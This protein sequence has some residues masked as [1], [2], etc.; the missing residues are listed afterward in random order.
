MT[1]GDRHGLWRRA[2]AS[3]VSS[4]S[5][6]AWPREIELCRASLPI[7]LAHPGLPKPLPCLSSWAFL[8][9]LAASST[10]L[11]RCGSGNT[12]DH[13]WSTNQRTSFLS[14]QNLTFLGS[15]EYCSVATFEPALNSHPQPV[16][17]GQMWLQNSKAILLFGKA[18]HGWDMLQPWNRHRQ[19][20][21]SSAQNPVNTHTIPY[22]QNPR[23]YVYSTP[24]HLLSSDSVEKL[25]RP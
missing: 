2:F 25:S 12:M 3:S 23:I 15:P 4:R 6:I 16:A 21:R 18:I 13:V 9:G 5:D 20:S 19:I 8:E 22:I 11:Y 24:L 17:L 1:P 7:W 14:P 10:K